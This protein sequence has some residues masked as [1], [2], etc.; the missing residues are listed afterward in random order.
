MTLWS[1]KHQVIF[2]CEWKHF[3]TALLWSSVPSHELG[4]SENLVTSLNY[5]SDGPCLEAVISTISRGI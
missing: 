4:T 5:R 2:E 1:L 3:E